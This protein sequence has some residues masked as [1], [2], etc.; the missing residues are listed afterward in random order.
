MR[1]AISEHAV[2]RYLER[3]DAR[4]RRE[5][6]RAHIGEAVESGE[7]R[8]LPP[9]WCF[10]LVAA[11]MSGTPQQYLETPTGAVL[12]AKVYA[13][14]HVVATIVTRTDL[15]TTLAARLSARGGNPLEQLA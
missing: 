2:E 14:R 6:A 4:A 15:D 9:L 13:E 3:V 8:D 1:V 7:W 5:V 11:E 12:V 10:H